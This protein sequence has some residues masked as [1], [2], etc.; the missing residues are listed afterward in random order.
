MLVTRVKFEQMFATNTYPDGHTC[1][2]R[3]AR[4]KPCKPLR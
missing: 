3:I 4:S 1:P 2:K